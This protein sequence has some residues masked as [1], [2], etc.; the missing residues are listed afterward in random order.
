MPRRINGQGFDDLV[1]QTHLNNMLTRVI[2]A[3]KRTVYVPTASTAG[4]RSHRQSQGFHYR[5]TILNFRK[6]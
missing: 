3:L 5:Q 4:A 1:K 6:D 2:G